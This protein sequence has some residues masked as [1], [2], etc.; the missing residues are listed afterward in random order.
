LEDLLA[1]L[2]EAA[3]R[4]AD[5]WNFRR[6]RFE[7]G[8]KLFRLDAATLEQRR[9]AHRNVVAA[10]NGSAEFENIEAWIELA[11]AGLLV[12]AAPHHPELFDEA[13]RVARVSR[14]ERPQV[15]ATQLELLFLLEQLARRRGA[16]D[17]ALRWLDE[18]EL[19]CDRL[20][21]SDEA[22]AP[23]VEIALAHAQLDVDL[24]RIELALG[25]LDGLR[26]DRSKVDSDSALRARERLTRANAYNALEQFQ[27]VL[28]TL[29]AAELESIRASDPANYA[30]MLVLRGEARNELERE[31]GSGAPTELVD[32]LAALAVPQIRPADALSA[33]LIL[34]DASLRCGD[35]D[36]AARWLD[37]CSR[38]PA[39][40]ARSR[41]RSAAFEVALSL[42]RSEPRERL[43][44]KAERL[45]RTLREFLSVWRGVGLRPGGLGFLHYGT[46][47]M[48]FSE[49][50]RACIA[51][52]PT[53]AGLERALALL[54]EA[55]AL[56]SV[57]RGMDARATLAEVRES[58]CGADRGVLLLL[59]SMDRSH[60]FAI[61]SETIVHSEACNADTLLRLSN[62]IH[63][64]V[65]APP[66]AD[67]A[68]RAERTRRI[69]AA[70]RE[71]SNELLP[72][73][74]CKR[75]RGWSAC[76]VVGADLRVST[77]FSCLLLDDDHYLGLEIALF[78]APSLAACVRLAE[79]ST[80]TVP[81]SPAD[82]AV[83]A[84]PTPSATAAARYP[85]ALALE[86]SREERARLTR[87]FDS[88]RVV[89]IDG[90]AASLDAFADARVRS[91]AALVVMAHGVA[92]E[93]RRADDSRRSALVLSPRS[94]DDDGLARCADIDEA[95]V[96]P[97]VELLSCGSARGALRVGDDTASHL[98]GSFFS[99]GAVVVLAAR[100][101]VERGAS[102]RLLAAFHEALSAPGG[103]PARALLAARRAIAAQAEFADPWY[104]AQFELHGSGWLDI[105]A[106]IRAQMQAPAPSRSWLGAGALL[107]LAFAA[108][109]V[110]RVRRRS[111][112]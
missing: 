43:V 35:L 102:T 99:A 103:S 6:A 69:L 77:P 29:D 31:S 42:G 104:W 76:V 39:H 85:D 108:W 59:P 18:A 17:E 53:V 105:A 24:G 80:P 46:Q 28:D 70:S 13:E 86:L 9:S 5:D 82:L 33:Q 112:A 84:D 79:R 60:V 38:S 100:T 97:L 32:L 94:L 90:A 110:L 68:K 8:V 107:V 75:V 22:W 93:A 74:I 58:V 37:D 34:A 21:P 3:S 78:E 92:A 30:L 109:I 71:L 88:E 66:P 81:S 87:G 41:A 23:R 57:A 27:R 111:R 89:W 50:T 55:Q 15:Q 98:V 48:P 65:D 83:I 49:W 19:A 44:A 96:A 91:A 63:E 51:L 64:I 12:D 47:R 101:D 36:S 25:R 40:D 11:W 7:C 106:P 52:D 10:A 72:P 4:G 95:R 20:P 26:A 45:E 67:P 73:E 16:F 54:L 61:D 2:E 1:K 56:E 14:A 62:G